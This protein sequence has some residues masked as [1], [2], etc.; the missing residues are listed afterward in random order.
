MSREPADPLD[1]YLNALGS[2]PPMTAQEERELWAA[3]RRGDDVDTARKR[4]IE[5]NVHLVPPIARRY[6]GPSGRRLADLV[7]EG[8]VGLARAVELFDPSADDDFTSFADR[9]IDDAI[10]NAPG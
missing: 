5:A 3:V 6:E 1:A 8:N 4:L 2:V 9:H 7:Q 10:S